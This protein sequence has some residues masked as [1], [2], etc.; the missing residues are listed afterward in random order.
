MLQ[1]LFLGDLF[2][3]A[4]YIASSSIETFYLF[5]IGQN[6]FIKSQLTHVAFYVNLKFYLNCTNQLKN[7]RLCELKKISR[8]FSG[9][10]F[11]QRS[12]KRA[13]CFPKICSN[14]SFSFFHIE[15]YINWVYR[16]QYLKIIY[17]NYSLTLKS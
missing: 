5:L 4:F 3:S 13:N 15:I 2:F 6:R 10:L 8:P 11:H 7:V 1:R 9:E 14:L 17:I 12:Y 16:N